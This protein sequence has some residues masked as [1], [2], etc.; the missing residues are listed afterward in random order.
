[1]K[2]NKITRDIFYSFLSCKKKACLKLNGETKSRKTDYHVLLDEQRNQIKTKFI[3]MLLNAENSH[4]MAFNNISYRTLSENYDYIFDGYFSKDLFRIEV[5]I[6]EKVSFQ[7]NLGNFSYIPI[8]PI[9]N[10]KPTNHDRLFLSL[11]GLI[12][13]FV[14]GVRPKYGKIIYSDQ[15]RIQ[16]IK[17]DQHFN[18]LELLVRN[19]ENLV[20]SNQTVSPILNRHCTVCE[21]RKLCR[22]CAIEE[23]H[24]SLL[25]G[26]KEKDIGKYNKKGIFTVNQLSYTFRPRRKRKKSSI[27]IIRQNFALKALALREN[28]TYIYEKPIFSNKSTKIF[29]DF[30]GLPG[31]G[32]CYLIGFLIFDKNSV[33][34]QSLW[35]DSKKEEQDI[36][37]EFINIIYDF[38]D[39]GLYHYGNYELKHLKRV[40]KTMDQSNREKANLIIDSCSNILSLIYS[41]IYFPTYSNSLKDIGKHLG[42]HWSEKEASGIQ[43]IVWRKKWEATNSKKYK[44]RLIQYNKED[45]YA[46]YSVVKF[47]ESINNRNDNTRESD[48]QRSKAI[49][50][51]DLKIESPFKFWNQEFALKEFDLINKSSYFDYQQEK[52]HVREYKLPRNKKP[53]KP[54]RAKNSHR[55]NK[56]I[57]LY[58]KNCPKCKNTNIQKKQQISRKVIDIKFTNGG[59][60]RWITRYKAFYY[61]CANCK[62]Q[63]LPIKY[64]SIKS[65]YGHDL[66]CWALFQYFDNNLSFIKIER[67]F[68][69]LFELNVP[70]TMI[71]EFK[72]YFLKYYNQTYLYIKKRILNSNVIYIDET[73]LKMKFESGYAWVI[74]N[75]SDTIA[76][77]KTSRE[78]KF[79][80]EYFKEFRG[81][82]VS[83]FYSAYDSL[84][85]I[86]QKCLIHLI[87]DL[88]DDLIKNPFNEEFK[89]L[90]KYFTLILQKIVS[91]IDKY[92]LKKRYLKKHKKDVEKFF[93]IILQKNYKTEISQKYQRRFSKNREKLFVFLDYDNV[94][95][96]NTNAEHAIKVLAT[97]RN[98]N[99]HSFHASRMDEYLAIMSI[100][101]TC[102]FRK[103]SF[104]R[105]LLSHEKDID[106][107]CKK[108]IYNKKIS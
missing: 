44:R 105:F 8:I 61:L 66:I 57:L 22:S 33:T 75:T 34:M 11:L 88:N 80:K 10:D 99:I 40:N 58:S 50:V 16:K 20:Q 68:Y 96:N 97:H 74:T 100:Y 21:F 73:P 64:K 101:I 18:A 5:D 82:I 53:N 7:S 2:N 78:G 84:E 27:N 107:Y 31:L 15:I 26:I 104:L 90:A 45:C 85:F 77:Y 93:K 95:W 39:C 59:I 23:D 79:L 41:H 65:K 42:F 6:L 29:F 76:F 4:L 86:Q 9:A 103:I 63:F 25:S 28:K 55:I 98:R 87:R 46:L 13:Q 12:L 106:K 36:F 69:D 71:H 35:A 72:N 17:L 19:I 81:I 108:Y 89:E 91:T 56:T 94:S 47:I 14:Q 49:F 37:Q 62:N 70:K 1:M 54:T 67:N 43:S 92:K 38:K 24:L 52:V 48:N 51:K 83:D 102:H 3:K 32:F 30:E 60:K